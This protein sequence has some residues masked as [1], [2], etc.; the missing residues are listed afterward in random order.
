[1]KGEDGCED[2][3]TSLLIMCGWEK[4]PVAEKDIALRRLV[5]TSVYM[6]NPLF[7][8]HGSAKL[9]CRRTYCLSTKMVLWKYFIVL[10]RAREYSKI[11]E[12][13]KWS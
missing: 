12:M 3:L 8:L 7:Q 9:D 5:N 6:N 13:V 10:E 1:M 2:L 4:S 11:Y